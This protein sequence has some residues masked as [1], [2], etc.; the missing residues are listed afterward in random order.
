[1]TKRIEAFV[2]Y[3]PVMRTN[4]VN[5]DRWPARFRRWT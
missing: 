2:D 3:V 5:L 4:A 1:V